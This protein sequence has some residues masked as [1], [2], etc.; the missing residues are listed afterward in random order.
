MKRRLFEKKLSH[1]GIIETEIVLETTCDQFREFPSARNDVND[2]S[3]KRFMKVGT[4]SSELKQVFFGSLEFR[5]NRKLG[6]S[7]D[8]QICRI[9]GFC[10]Q[11]F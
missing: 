11:L 1:F 7:V 8:A 2:P 3:R 9:D 10:V 6:E 5:Q 4:V